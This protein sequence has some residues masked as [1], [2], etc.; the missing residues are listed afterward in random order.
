ML[1]VLVLVAV[2]AGFW[3]RQSSHTERTIARLADYPADGILRTPTG[4]SRGSVRYEQQ[5]RVFKVIYALM[6]Q[7]LPEGQAY[8]GWLHDLATQEYRYAGAFYPLQDGQFALAFT[9]E[10]DI[11]RFQQMVVSREVHA[12]PAA[13]T[14]VVSGGALQIESPPSPTPAPS[15]VEAP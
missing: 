7:P 12:A 2:A 8:H 15:P 1:G 5:D 13:P 14:D 3:W 9:T 6:A 10:E 11:S 4:E